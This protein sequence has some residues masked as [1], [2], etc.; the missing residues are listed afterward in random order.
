[1]SIK[2][3]ETRD[4]LK[5][6]LKNRHLIFNES[7]LESALNTHN[8]FSLFNGLETIFLK[9]TNP[10]DYNNIKLQDFLNLYDF[11]K[12]I[13][14]ILSNCL[15]TV[16]EKL[17]A[18]IS[19][20]FAAH[21]CA[22]LNDTM[23]YTNKDNYMN[24]AC[25]IPSDPCYCRYSASYPFKSAQNYKIYNDFNSFDLFNSDYLSK[26]ISKYDHI[27]LSF[28]Q[29]S[30]YIAPTN[31]AVYSD[32]RN[33]VNTHVAVPFW[34]TI[35]T[36]TFGQILRLLHYLQD[37]V[38]DDVLSDFKLTLSKRNQ[39][40]NMM[41]VLLCL[42]NSCAHTTLINR[43]RTSERYQINAQLVTA[44][45]LSPKNNGS[46]ISVLKL[47]DV[48]KILS[49]FTDVSELKKPL[50]KLIIHNILSMGPT[51]A[52][53]INKR[54]LDRMGNHSYSEW[55]KMLSGQKYLL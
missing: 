26:L 11:D 32:R 42:R 35:E 55:I 20:H 15:D 47:F 6:K 36:L 22:S 21:H 33:G 38:M 27:D 8:Y 3:F 17:K 28:Y 4:S 30:N 53:E 45:N 43:F 52:N 37:D 18:S 50:R 39:F 12:N 40:L 34:V 5:T 48:I 24:P 31:V 49:F 13:T 7:E 51:K 54:I 41:D 16:E 19:Y 1:M 10:K 2:T 14:S 46:P 9:S 23:Q 25:A 44:F 29:D